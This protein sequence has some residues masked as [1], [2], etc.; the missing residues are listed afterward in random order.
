MIVHYTGKHRYVSKACDALFRTKSSSSSS[1]TGG[2]PSIL[3]D[4]VMM[5]EVL[6]GV[7]VR[8]P[9]WLDWNICVSHATLPAAFL[10]L[11]FSQHVDFRDTAERSIRSDLVSSLAC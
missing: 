3:G 11:D 10:A 9:S 4:S 2:L 5:L 7:R 1:I 8:L 6:D